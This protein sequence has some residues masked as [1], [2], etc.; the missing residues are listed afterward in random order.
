MIVFFLFLSKKG[1]LLNDIYDIMHIYHNRN[2]REEESMTEYMDIQAVIKIISQSMV[3]ME[4]RIKEKID[5]TEALLMEEVNSTGIV[6]KCR[7]SRLKDRL[8]ELKQEQIIIKS[9]NDNT[10][11]ILKILESYDNRLKVLEAKIL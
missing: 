7:V 5:E 6:A 2:Q 3:D 11:L 9:R 10:A 1:L 4:T 8:E